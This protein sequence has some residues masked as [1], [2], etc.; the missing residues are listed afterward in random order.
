M[1]DKKPFLW[2]VAF[3]ILLVAI[4]T[5]FYVLGNQRLQNSEFWQRFHPVVAKSDSQTAKAVEVETRRRL[6]HVVVQT[7]RG[8]YFLTGADF[9]PGDGEKVV[10]QRNDAWELYLCSESAAHCATIHSFCAERVWPDI[11]RDENGRVAG[12]YAPHLGNGTNVAVAAITNP[13][14]DRAGQEGGRSKV[15]PAVGMSH[16]RE[17]AWRMGLPR[18]EP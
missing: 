9:V 8:L 1:L 17:W 5:S 3:V 10:V 18:T 15:I 2:A 13:P 14:A 16:P 11:K 4:A 6:A 7:E 12:C